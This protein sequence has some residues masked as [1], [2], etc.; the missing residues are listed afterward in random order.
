MFDAVKIQGYDILSAEI[1][2]HLGIL[3]VYLVQDSTG[4]SFLLSAEESHY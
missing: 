1:M 2:D 4:L 3:H